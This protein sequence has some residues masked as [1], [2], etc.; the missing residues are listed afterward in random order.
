VPS[1]ILNWRFYPISIEYSKKLNFCAGREFDTN[2][3]NQLLLKL[4]IKYPD[5]RF[6]NKFTFSDYMI[7]TLKGEKHQGPLV[8]HTSFRFS[9]NIG[10]REKNLLEYEKYLNQIE[11]SFDTNKEMCVKKKI[12][13]R[14][15]S[16]LAYKIL[17]KV[18]FKTNHDNSFIA[19][20]IPSS[21]TLSEKQIA[22]LSDQLEAVY[23]INGYYVQEVEEEIPQQKTIT[24]AIGSEGKSLEISATSKELDAT[25]ENTVWQEIRKGLIEEFGEAIDAVWFSKA[26]SKECAETNTLT[27]TMPT[28]F[29]AGF[30]KNANLG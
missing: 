14:F 6:K 22:T 1:L 7:K 2:F 10:T 5:K 27:L 29:M 18:E 19:V 24:S 23:G 17:T 30:L 28:R 9:C 13:G 16:E 4:Y 8:N 12:A 3:T 15:S 21:L 26:V 11:N 25:N 20:L